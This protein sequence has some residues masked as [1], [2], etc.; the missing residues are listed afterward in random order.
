[1]QVGSPRSITSK[2]AGA[3]EKSAWH[4]LTTMAW[5]VEERKNIMEYE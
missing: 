4:S 3:E 2:I 1:M 5:L